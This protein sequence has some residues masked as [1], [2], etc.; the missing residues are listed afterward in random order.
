MNQSRLEDMQDNYCRCEEVRL[1]WYVLG[2]GPFIIITA[3]E[4]RM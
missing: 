3:Q 2:L 4:E 1:G